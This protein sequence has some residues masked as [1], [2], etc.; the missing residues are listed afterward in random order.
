MSTVTGL[1][2]KIRPDPALTRLFKNS[3]RKHNMYIGLHGK[4][5]AGKDTVLERLQIISEK[6]AR[7]AFA[8]KM[9][10]SAMASLGFRHHR[11]GT[12]T[13][14]ELIHFA[15]LLKQ[16][17]EITVVITIPREGSSPIEVKKVITGREYLQYSGTEGGRDVFGR[18]F[19]AVQGMDTA[20]PLAQEGKTPTA[21]DVRFPEEAEAI[22][23]VRGEVWEIVGP[24]DPEAEE[25]HESETRL[26]DH[27]IT[28]TI[29][30]TERG[31]GFK[32][33]DAQLEKLVRQILGDV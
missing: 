20:G 8:D 22:M 31:D 17:G 11:T 2:M 32:S 5:T 14:D 26:P 10:I 24:E 15:N 6:F 9:K 25:S 21:T 1:A 3:T 23:G 16:H 29:D 18:D 7:F 4:M 30:N 12:T 28:R 19:W 33:L 27:M 13:D